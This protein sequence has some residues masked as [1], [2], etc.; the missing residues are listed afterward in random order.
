MTNRDYFYIKALNFSFKEQSMEDIL[1]FVAVGA[2][3]IVYLFVHLWLG[4][5][6]GLDNSLGG[7]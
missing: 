4:P 5:R 2:A 7:S 3:V 6:I 1:P